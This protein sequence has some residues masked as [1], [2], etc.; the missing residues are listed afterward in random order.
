MKSIGKR[1][2]SKVTFKVHRKHKPLPKEEERKIPENTSDI[3][4][5]DLINRQQ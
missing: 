4:P 3:R 2:A 1:K 5:E